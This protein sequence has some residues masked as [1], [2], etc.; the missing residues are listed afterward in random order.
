MTPSFQEALISQIP[1]LRTLQ[2]LGY[3]Y[4]TPEEVAVARQGKMGRVLLEDVLTQQLRRLN[5]ISFKGREVAFS[6]ENIAKES[7][8]DGYRFYVQRYFQLIRPRE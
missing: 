3:H 6:E 7:I 5:K 2:Q 4:L 1:A 8:P